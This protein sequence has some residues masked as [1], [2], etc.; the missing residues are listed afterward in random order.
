MTLDM[1]AIRREFPLLQSKAYLNNCSY[2]VLSRTVEQAFER[3]LDSRRTHGSQWEVWVGQLEVLRGALARLLSC[4]PADISV[5]ASLSESVNALATSLDFSAGRDTVVVTDFDFPSSSQ[6]W[7]AQQRRGARVL[8]ARADA[9]GVHIPLQAF[10]ALIDE[11]TALVSLPWVCYRNGVKLDLGPVIELAHQRGA[12]VFVDGYQA[13]GTFPF[14]APEIGADFLAGGCLKYLLGTAGVA[15]LYVRDSERM[16][17]VPTATGWFAQEDPNAMDIYHHVPAQSA[18]RFE[19]GTPAVAAT[20]ACAAGVDQLL[21]V[22][23]DAVDQQ[24]RYLT[25]L[26]AIGMQ[27]RGWRLTT[28]ASPERHGALMA[29][30][31]TDA[32][33]LVRRLAAEGVVASDRDNNLRVSPHFYN[34]EGDVERLFRALEKHSDLL[35][36][37]IRREVD[38]L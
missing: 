16:V 23:L 5:S 3:Y 1:A 32:P 4:A 2:G 12:L 33:E 34:D 11:R 26:I 38:R 24:I 21:Q 30:A 9:S 8:R 15:Y 7:L 18:R 6:I 22:G 20:Y 37:E 17:E 13:V 35:C 19:S 31:S 10:D 36:D 25:G 28:P 29:I 27:E 14:A